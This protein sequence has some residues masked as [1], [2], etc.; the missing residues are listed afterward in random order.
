[1]KEAGVSETAEGSDFLA[2]A[3]PSEPIAQTPRVWHA[4]CRKTI[5]KQLLMLFCSWGGC[6]V[7]E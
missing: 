3:I 4:E 7:G 1:M 6:V 5:Y 2:A